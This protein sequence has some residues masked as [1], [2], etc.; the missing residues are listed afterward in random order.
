[1]PVISTDPALEFIPQPCPQQQNVS[2]C[3]VHALY[4]TRV[5]IQRLMHPSYRPARPWDLS[6]IEPDTP[7]NRAELRALF[8]QK[9]VERITANAE[10]EVPV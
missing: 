8:Q 3:G 5:L 1:M 7:K 4:N 2:D 9:W 6:D 10:R